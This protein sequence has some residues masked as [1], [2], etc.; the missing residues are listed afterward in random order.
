MMLHAAN[1]QFT[2]KQHFNLAISAN[3]INQST[4]NPIALSDTVGVL[5][6]SKIDTAGW[7]VSLFDNISLV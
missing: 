4:R 1:G 5:F 6:S 3:T 7:L 2:V